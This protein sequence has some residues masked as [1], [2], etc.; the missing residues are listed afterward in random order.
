MFTLTFS[1][2]YSDQQTPE[3]GRRAKKPSKRCDN[4]HE[5]TDICPN[6]NN[7]NNDNSSS[8]KRPH[9]P[10]KFRDSSSLFG[11]GLLHLYKSNQTDDVR[12]RLCVA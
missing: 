1:E 11:L 4:S 5:D 3:E 9:P 8:Q 10:A 12:L 6:V 2:D 7:M